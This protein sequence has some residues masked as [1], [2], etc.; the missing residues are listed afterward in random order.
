[1]TRV[2]GI[3]TYVVALSAAA[4][5]AACGG[6]GGEDDAPASQSYGIE[7]L[8]PAVAEAVGGEDTVHLGI[9]D[10]RGRAELQV[11]LTWAAKETEFRALMGDTPGDFL[12]FRRV[13]GKMYVGGERTDNE[14]SYTADDDPRALGDDDSFDAG[15]APVLLALDVP[16]DYEAMIDA[17]DKVQ[18]QGQ[19]EM[20]GVA[21]THYVL[22][23]DAQAWVDQFPDDSMH[24]QI[25]LD[26]ALQVDLWIDEQSLPVRME[27]TGTD[28][29]DQA[30][31]DYSGW[32]T[33]IA[34]VVPEGATP[35]GSEAS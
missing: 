20:E 33:P 35:L 28:T 4:V 14:W 7:T 30:R 10:H 8:M 3:P 32:G 21:S 31:V 26:D 19:E 18:N 6:G 25:E 15:A 23:I 11:D 9:G 17:V 2:T 13:G 5:L 12:E 1:M 27:Y 16:G 24:R 34:V 22:T 29:G